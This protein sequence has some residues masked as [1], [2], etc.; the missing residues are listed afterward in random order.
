[1]CL[2]FYFLYQ[3]SLFSKIFWI[4]CALIITSTFV[5]TMLSQVVRESCFFTEKETNEGT[6]FSLF[7][8][9]HNAY[10]VSCHL[11]Q[12]RCTYQESN[13]QVI[14]PSQIQLK[15]SGI[16]VPL[17]VI[18]LQAC[19]L[20]CDQE[21]SYPYPHAT[22]PTTHFFCSPNDWIQFSHLDL[23]MLTSILTN[24]TH[25]FW[26]FSLLGIQLLWWGQIVNASILY[27]QARA[28]PLLHS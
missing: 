24:V 11:E 20:N 21:L 9:I 23:G 13:A 8:F 5:L 7:C 18:S 14:S 6:W 2:S 26:R 1:M 3:N 28:C 25:L 12:G 19:C 15:H 10:M 22:F 27:T 16:P 4:L 17:S